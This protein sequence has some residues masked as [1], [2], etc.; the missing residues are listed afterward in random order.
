MTR[1]KALI[2]LNMFC[3]IG[4]RRLKELLKVFDNPED[5][6]KSPF[7]KLTQVFGIGDNIAAKIVSLRERDID[8]EIDLAQKH[9]LKIIPIDDKDYPENL[10]QIFDP[11]IVLYVK[12]EILKEDNFALGIVGSRQASRAGAYNSYTL[13]GG[14]KLLRTCSPF[15]GIVVGSHTR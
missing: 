4:S 11:P 6:L 5:I 9:N 1:L 3:D 10:R 12:G 7:D 15:A 8:E 2:G 13:T 14:W